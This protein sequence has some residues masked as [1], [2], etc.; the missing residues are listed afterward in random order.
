MKH[1]YMITYVN[2][3][4]PYDQQTKGRFVTHADTINIALMNA[5]AILTHTS[6]DNYTI[7]NINQE[8]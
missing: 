4:T 2:N 3:D 7:I 5:D 1:E 6:S 8:D